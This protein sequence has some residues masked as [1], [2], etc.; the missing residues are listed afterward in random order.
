MA[1]VHFDTTKDK[2]IATTRAS[3]QRTY[4]GAYPSEYEANVAQAKY[5]EKW[6]ET[7]PDYDQLA[8]DPD[9][10]A[11]KAKEIMK[12]LSLRPDCAKGPLDA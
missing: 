6:Y 12:Q 5:L 4:I 8:K 11:K 7:H 1:G 2:W 3:G 9:A 10:W